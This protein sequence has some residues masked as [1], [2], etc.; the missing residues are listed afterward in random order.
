MEPSSYQLEFY[1]N[2]EGRKPVLDWIRELDQQQRRALGTAMREILQTLGVEVCG[3]PFG[4]QLGQGLFAFRLRQE[5]LL[6]RV[7]CHAYGNRVILLLGGYDKGADPSPKR[8]ATEIEEARRR[9][10]N[11]RR[12]PR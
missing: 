3:T 9:L 6:L 5:G 10:A 2:E 11:W 1:E 4:K 7:F 12:R 8:Q